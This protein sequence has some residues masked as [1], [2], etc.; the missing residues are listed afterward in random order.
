MGL[1]YNFVLLKLHWNHFKSTLGRVLS[2][3]PWR[4]GK[5][6]ITRDR[7]FYRLYSSMAPSHGH[8]RI[9]R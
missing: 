2:Y 8:A 9:E 4:T 5:E 1:T 6:A 3:S 7:A